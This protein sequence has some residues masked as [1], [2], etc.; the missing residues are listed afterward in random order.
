MYKS[1]QKGHTYI[2]S[3]NTCT[4]YMYTHRPH[5]TSGDSTVAGWE[6]VESLDSCVLA[7]TAVGPEL[8]YA[9]I[10]IPSSK[11]PNGSSFPPGNFKADS[12]FPE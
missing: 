8:A 11:L 10:D 6:G 3:T 7:A 1:K 12:G 4:V 5:H 2:T 9:C